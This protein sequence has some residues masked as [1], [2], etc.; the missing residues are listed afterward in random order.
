MAASECPAREALAGYVYGTLAEADVDGVADHVESCPS[1]ANTVGRLEETADSLLSHLRSPPSPVE[2]TA[3]TGCDDV[4]SLLARMAP[5]VPGIID[6]RSTTPAPSLGLPHRLRSYELETLLACGGMG[7]VYRARHTELDRIVA[8][9][10]LS[11]GRM[12]DERGVARFKREMRAVGR[13]EHPNIVR[14]MDAGEEA[15]THYLVTEFVDGRDLSSLAKERG[16]LPVPEACEIIRQAAV[17]LQHIHEHG[18]VH[19]DIKPSNLMLARDGTVRILDL[20][21]VLLQESAPDSAADL[22]SSGRI[23]GTIDYM[24]PEQAADSHEVDIRADIF[25]LG[26]TLYKLLTGHSPFSGAPSNS[27]ARKL[28]ALAAAD[29]GPLR[30]YRPDVSQPLAELVAMMLAKSPDRR[31]PTPADAARQLLPFCAGA[32]LAGL[33]ATG[34]V[35]LGAK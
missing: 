32:D 24:A 21:L 19:R 5:P 31:P 10:L 33:L 6:D 2:L 7:A 8:V 22:T 13:L 35:K 28:S 15:G 11:A 9:K 4:V 29:P 16:A 14:A 23:M 27:L 17:G 25:S 34:V 30:E 3:A 12:Q 1:C 20:G 26:A 18:L